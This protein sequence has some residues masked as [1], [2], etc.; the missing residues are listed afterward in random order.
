[1]VPKS[2]EPMPRVWG[3]LLTWDA[4]LDSVAVS[5]P[6]TSDAVVPTTSS[7]PPR[8][9]LTVSPETRKRVLEAPS[10]LLKN[11][12][13]V[14]RRHVPASASP[15]IA[16]SNRRRHVPPS[17]SSPRRSWRGVSSVLARIDI[18]STCLL[19]CWEGL[20]RMNRPVAMPCS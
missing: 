12:S 10:P 7:P 9:G 6:A 5:A 19:S 4:F 17:P 8:G 3:K 11:A 2:T 15:P 18:R 16:P 1:V 20:F 14:K 13:P